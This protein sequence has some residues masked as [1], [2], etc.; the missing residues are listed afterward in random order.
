VAWISFETERRRKE[1]E[2]ARKAQKKAEREAGPCAK[3]QKVA[4][5]ADPEEEEFKEL[6]MKLWAGLDL[7][8]VLAQNIY[9]GV[10]AINP[11]LNIKE[12]FRWDIEDC[13]LLVS[14]PC[15]L[16]PYPNSKAW[17]LPAKT[18]RFPAGVRAKMP[19]DDAAPAAVTGRLLSFSPPPPPCVS[20]SLLTFHFCISWWASGA[21]GSGTVSGSGGK[22]G[23]VGGGKSGKGRT[24][25]RS[26]SEQPKGKVADP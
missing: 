8:K 5:E 19:P 1:K 9:T 22:S 4:P 11:E 2:T 6:I 23:S 16:E 10:L 26:E 17:G 18:F 20:S 25:T 13:S 12:N 21:G 3:K 7:L 14:T 24:Q 15:P